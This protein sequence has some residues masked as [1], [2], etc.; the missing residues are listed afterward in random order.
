[1]K[2]NR[3]I[4]VSAPLAHGVVTLASLRTGVYAFSIVLDA[5]RQNGLARNRPMAGDY[6]GHEGRIRLVGNGDV[7]TTDV[8]VF[9]MLHLLRPEDTEM[10]LARIEECAHV[11]APVEF[12]WEPVPLAT[13]Y[14]CFVTRRWRK[15]QSWS[16]DYT[17]SSYGSET[18]C[19]FDLPPN[20]PGERYAISIEAEGDTGRLTHFEDPRR[21][22]ASEYCFVVQ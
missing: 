7:A 18:A 13:G 9:R 2:T 15:G 22:W 20:A 11:S 17:Q 4:R 12:E 16:S 10:G 19:R 21:G 14:R 5:N 6:E 3:D 1:M 8:K